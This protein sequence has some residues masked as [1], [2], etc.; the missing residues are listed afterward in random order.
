[1]MRSYVRLLLFALALAAAPLRLAAQEEASQ[2]ADDDRAVET[3]RDA[4]GGWRAP[5]WYDS[6]QDAEKPIRIAPKRTSAINWWAI[7]EPTLW[8]LAFLLLGLLAYVIIRAFM[9]RRRQPLTL[10]ATMR[11]QRALRAE[12]GRI[13]ALPF[14]LERKPTSLLDEAER[15]YRAGEYSQAIIY[16]F[17]YQLVE[18]DTGEEIDECKNLIFANLSQAHL[19]CKVILRLR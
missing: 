12:V 10:S 7:L 3:V 9:E 1:M 2:A 5:P 11:G 6:S 15:L 13:E 8:C 18:M 4:L 19:N 17:S 16:L 14:Q